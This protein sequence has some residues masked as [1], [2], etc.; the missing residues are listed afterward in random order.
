MQEC[1][2]HI[3]ASAISLVT[4]GP[5]TILQAMIRHSDPMSPI[6][7]PFEAHTC[8]GTIEVSIAVR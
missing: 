7:T 1:E 8:E 6:A 5:S 2:T 3:A 4:T